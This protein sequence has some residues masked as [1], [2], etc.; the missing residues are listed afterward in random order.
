MKAMVF[1]GQGSQFT[2]MGEELFDEFDDYVRVADDILG[3]SIKE[4]CLVDPDK[5][6][7]KTQYTQPALYVVNALH[8]L[9]RTQT[10]NE[11]IDF[12]AG[13]SLGEFTAL[14][15]AGAFSFE[16]GLRLVKKRGELM[17]TANN[18]AMAAIIGVDATRV[19]DILKAPELSSIDVANY[20]SPTQT[21][22][23]G[24]MDDIEIA[25]SIFEEQGA[26]FV[27]LPVSAA[28]HSR[29][30][31]PIEDAFSQYLAHFT[32]GKLTVPVISNATAK[33]YQDDSIAENLTK[34]LSS[35]VQWVDSIRFINAN[36]QCRFEE[37][38]PGD[39]LSKLICAIANKMN[40]KEAA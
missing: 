11:K 24:S 31:K 14:F 25:Q 36:G 39:V 17:S 1:P 35:S 27:K 19:N 3:Y 6:L 20:N 12:F 21:V 33:P 16:Q 26:I 37:V 28:F 22:V 15:A 32:F 34:Q 13:H 4:L 9:K 7:S 10:L 2:G 38:G 8:Y 30:M 5:V 18:G 29:Y 40:N 23:S